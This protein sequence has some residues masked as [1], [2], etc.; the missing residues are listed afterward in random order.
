MKLFLDTADIEHIKKWSE[1]GLIDGVTTN[2]SHLS[3]EA[4]LPTDIIRQIAHILPEGDISVEVT[5]TEPR[6]VYEQAK[7]IVQL[8]DN[9]IV[10]IPCHS[11]YFSVIAQLVAEDVAINITLVFSSL[12]AVAMAKLGVLYVSPFVGRIDDMG[13][14][15]ITVIEEIKEIYTCYGFETEI[16]AA[17]IRSVKDMKGALLAGAD[18]ITIPIDICE[19]AFDHPLTLSGMQKFMHDWQQLGIKDFPV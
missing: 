10:K 7:K 19:K 18:C 15:G 11:S 3:K 17:S 1:T 12:Q 14:D 8:G 16:L 2:P 4:G 5:E 13:Y 6:A 9:M